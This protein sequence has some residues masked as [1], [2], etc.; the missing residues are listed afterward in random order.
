ME[1]TKK[2]PIFLAETVPRHK[3]KVK[4]S[5]CKKDFITAY[6]Y[7]VYCND[8]CVAEHKPKPKKVKKVLEGTAGQR[9]KI[10]DEARRQ[11]TL[12]NRKYMNIMRK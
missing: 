3:H 5:K 9:K 1:D 6:S 2:R 10:R 8:P 4:C 12:L 11:D 7:Q